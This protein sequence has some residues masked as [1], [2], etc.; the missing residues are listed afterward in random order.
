MIKRIVTL[1]VCLGLMTSLLSASA[2]E[3]EYTDVLAEHWAYSDIVKARQCGLMEGYEDGRFGL[4]D[5]LTRASFT[6]VLCRMF[7]WESV[8]S[9]TPSYIDCPPG[10]WYYPYVETALANGALEDS[11]AFRPEDPITREEMAIMLVRA[12]GYDQLAQAGYD[13]D[14]PFCDVTRNEAYVALAWQI[15]LIRGVEQDGLRFFQPYASATREEAAAMLVRVYERYTSPIEWLHGFYAFSSFSQI[16]LTDSMDAVS[17]GWAR[18]D[19]NEETGPWINTTS[20]DGNSWTIPLDPEAATGHLD[21]NGTPYNLNI[22]SD[23]SAILATEESRAAAVQ[24]V[25]AAAADYAGITMDF[26]GLRAANKDNFTAF[27]TALRAALPEDKTLYVCVTPVVPDDS[28]Y[29][30]YDYRALGE[31][32][33]KVILM[34]HDYQYTSV[35][36]GYLGTT[37]TNSPL[38]PFNKIYYALAAITDPETGVADPSKLALAISFASVGWRIDEEDKILEQ[39]SYHPAPAT[40]I[41]RLRQEDTLM[42]WSELYRNAYIYYTTEDGGR[43]RLWYEDARST[44]EKVE[45]AR[46]F[47]ITGVSLWRLGNV[48]NYDDEGLYYDAWGSL[49]SDR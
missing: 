32:C 47:G 21:R 5:S 34:A 16:D 3:P 4:G 39:S 17:L 41:T 7:S 14:L 24:A 13:F 1:L 30:G 15:G 22:Y 48:P 42:G 28:Y 44:M 46:M 38:T 49:L 45:L 27:M 29:D 31:L 20:A 12:L 9:D 6:A 26:E 25:A 36:V 18:L 37:R 10:E 33:D 8:P 40:V 11:A 43:Y 2:A 35:P 19:W 23:K